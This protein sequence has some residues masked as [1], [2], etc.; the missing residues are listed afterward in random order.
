MININWKLDERTPHTRL[1]TLSIS[2]IRLRLRSYQ[3]RLKSEPKVWSINDKLKVIWGRQQQQRKYV[4]YPLFNFFTLLLW[5]ARTHTR[6]H[7]INVSVRLLAATKRDTFTS[8]YSISFHCPWIHIYDFQKD[9]SPKMNAILWKS[10]YRIAKQHF[11][12]H[13]QTNVQMNVCP[14]QM[15]WNEIKWSRN[16]WN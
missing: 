9:K 3:F 12:S 11:V 5:H 6:T 8:L 2:F 1:P 10:T 13:K 4:K 7:F 14:H 16:K 15:K